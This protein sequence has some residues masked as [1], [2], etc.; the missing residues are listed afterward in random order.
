VAGS[1]EKD[2]WEAQYGGNWTFDTRQGTKRKCYEFGLFCGQ[3][4]ILD[5]F[6][7]DP[8]VVANLTDASALA[9]INFWETQNTLC[10]VSIATLGS[11]CVNTSVFHPTAGPNDCQLY[12]TPVA[13]EN[14]R[15]SSDAYCNATCP[16]VCISLPGIDQCVPQKKPGTS[17]WDEGCLALRGFQNIATSNSS[18]SSG[19]PSGAFAF[20]PFPIASVASSGAAGPAVDSSG[21]FESAEALFGYYVLGQDTILIGGSEVGLPGQSVSRLHSFLLRHLPEHF[22]S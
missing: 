14:C 12:N 21:K 8:A 7:A 11:P 5:V 18:N 19:A 9:A 17:C 6:K 2:T 10:P 15:I 16:T 1:V 13:K 20:T 3:M 22:V 4:G